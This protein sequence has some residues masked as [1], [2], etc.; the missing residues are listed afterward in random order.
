LTGCAPIRRALD[1]ALEESGFEP[2]VPLAKSPRLLR[3]SLCA[4]SPASDPVA[5]LTLI[6]GVSWQVLDPIG[7]WRHVAANPIQQPPDK[8]SRP[9]PSR[10]AQPERRLDLCVCI[11]KRAG[12]SPTFVERR[13][14]VDRLP[15][16]ADAMRLARWPRLSRRPVHRRGSADDH[17]IAHAAPYRHRVCD[18]VQNRRPGLM[19]FCML[20]TWRRFTP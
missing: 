1:S 17:G 8:Q 12:F 10:N 19:L 20:S 9:S 14:V 2:L 11:A 5:I 6:V 16:L 13:D 4:L 3:V 15:F 18:R 7:R